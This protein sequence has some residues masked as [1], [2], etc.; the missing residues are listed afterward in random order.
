MHHVGDRALTTLPEKCCWPPAFYHFQMN[1]S[2]FQNSLLEG[3]CVISFCW[4]LPRAGHVPGILHALPPT[5][6]EKEAS[7]HSSSLMWK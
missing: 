6:S 1:V 4:S 3:V 2:V 7:V 5:L